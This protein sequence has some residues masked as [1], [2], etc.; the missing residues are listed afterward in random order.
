MRGSMAILKGVRIMPPKYL[1]LSL[2]LGLGWLFLHAAV[3][4]LTTEGGW[5][6]T[7]FLTHATKGPLA[8]FFQQIAGAAAV[9][10]LV[11]VG[12]LSIGIALVLGL[13][14]RFT[15]LA[16][17]VMLALFYLAQLPS[18]DGWIDSKIVYILALNM[19][20]VAQAGT[21]WGIDGLI[22]GMERRVPKLRYV[23]G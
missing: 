21:F 1:L 20:A 19:L 8:D 4:K 17:S 7:G 14:T 3:E 10:W 12:E 23:L 5:T 6:A 2:R 16:G 9:D 18:W 13:A 22:E 15:V 11:M